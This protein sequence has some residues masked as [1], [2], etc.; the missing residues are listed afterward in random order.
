[1]AS[2]K[3]HSGTPWL[4]DKRASQYTKLVMFYLMVMENEIRQIV[5][6][7]ALVYKLKERVEI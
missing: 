2:C 6:K 3:E 5:N 7:T 1:M 4:Q